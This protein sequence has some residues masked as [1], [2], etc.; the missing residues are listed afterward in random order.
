MEIEQLTCFTALEHTGNFSTAAN[1]LFISQ[2]SLSKK[3]KAMETELGF[4]LFDR[5]TRHLQLTEAGR[6]FSIYAHR[7]L[8]EYRSMLSETRAFVENSNSVIRIASI[9]VAAHYGLLPSFR[10]FQEQ[11]PDTVLSI[12]EGDT[13]F[14][15]K[16]L[17]KG[18][19]DIAIMRSVFVP[20]D[21]FVVTPL[22]PD[23]MVLL[24][25]AHHRFARCSEISLRDAAD[26]TFCFLN[27]QTGFYKMCIQLCEAA[28]FYPYMHQMNVSRHTIKDLIR[29]NSAVSLIMEKVAEDLLSP[30]LRIVH[31]KEHPA[32]DIAIV[33]RSGTHSRRCA[34]F[35]EYVRQAAAAIYAGDTPGIS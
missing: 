23:E 17:A 11:N 30:D 2:S 13:D 34:S 24:V 22:L 9:P 1:E 21:G 15:L 14:V 3:I 5:N 19:A 4:T 18:N 29:Q 31:L 33:T 7:I 27:N 20:Q 26:E 32:L 28:G 8:M 35:I 12:N 6:V 16:E 10:T 25:N